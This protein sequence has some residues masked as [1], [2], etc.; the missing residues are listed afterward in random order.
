M[1]IVPY[2][3]MSKQNEIKEFM[4]MVLDIRRRGGERVDVDSWGVISTFTLEK[5]SGFKN[6]HN[7]EGAYLEKQVRRADGSVAELINYY[8]P[9]WFQRNRKDAGQALV[10]Y[11]KPIGPQSGS[12]L[13]FSEGAGFIHPNY[14]RE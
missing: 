5:N 12:G 9:M 14:L 4:R 13:L 1:H 6:E 8:I 10:S 11:T 7:A 2:H 3:R